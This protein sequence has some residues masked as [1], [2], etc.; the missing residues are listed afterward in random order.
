MSESRIRR[1][2]LEKEK[3]RR[4]ALKTQPL[5]KGVDIREPRA[6]DPKPPETPSI[7]ETTTGILKGLGGELEGISEGV[8]AGIDFAGEIIKD[9]KAGFETIKNVSTQIIKNAP[10]IGLDALRDTGRSFGIGDG[11]ALDVFAAKFSESPLSTM[12]DLFLVTGMVNAGRKFVQAGVKVGVKEAAKAQVRTALGRSGNKIDDIV[13]G[14]AA[15]DVDTPVREALKNRKK[16]LDIKPEQLGNRAFPKAVSEKLS[17]TMQDV[18][19]LDRIALDKALD[20]V[21]DI[22]INKTRV[23][24]SIVTELKAKGLMDDAGNLSDDIRGTFKVENE[25]KRLSPTQE[26]ILPKDL[27]GRRQ[28][29]DGSINFNKDVMTPQDAALEVIADNYRAELKIISPEFAERANITSDRLRNFKKDFKS[30][31]EMGDGQKIANSLF[32]SPEKIEAFKEVLKKTAPKRLANK[33]IDELE[34]IGAWRAWDNYWGSLQPRVPGGIVR[35]VAEPIVKSF[36]RERLTPVGR[37]VAATLRGTKTPAR[38]GL[39][40]LSLQEEN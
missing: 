12:S 22:P 6:F 27:R 32:K 26:N 15:T 35:P 21:K 29:L 3:R 19:K 24:N 17:K 14:A 11:N 34:T 8:L 23:N 30:A 10:Q 9:P 7:G 31:K 33:A 4:A 40:A 36:A 28:Q 16:I 20:G 2:K 25:L 39:K 37:G 38:V 5:E 1:L 13:K 18:E